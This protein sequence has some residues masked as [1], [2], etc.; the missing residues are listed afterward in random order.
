MVSFG[1]R[2]SPP[3]SLF[4]AWKQQ[5]DSDQDHENDDGVHEHLLAS[6]RTG[7]V[8]ST[9]R[10]SEMVRVGDDA[11]GGRKKRAKTSYLPRPDFIPQYPNPRHLTFCRFVVLAVVSRAE[12]QRELRDTQSPDIKMGYA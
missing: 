3:E 4:P 11:E 8:R 6:G 12:N 10:E 1:V 7:V 2:F 5:P 9:D